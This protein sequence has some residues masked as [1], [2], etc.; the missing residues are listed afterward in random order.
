[1]INLK[2]LAIPVLILCFLF[3]YSESNAQIQDI[4]KKSRSNQSKKKSSK[5]SSSSRSSSSS[6]SSESDFDAADAMGCLFDAID[7]GGCLLSIFSNS[8]DDDDDYNY[9]SNSYYEE[10]YEYDYTPSENESTEEISVEY[11]ENLP[12]KPVE[13]KVVEEPPVDT[14]NTNPIVTKTEVVETE[15]IPEVYNHVPNSNL[16]TL[17]DE[18]IED[19]KPSLDINGNFA[20]AF[21]KGIDRN[22]TYVNF[23]PGLRANLGQVKFD[24]RFN[25]LTEFTDNTPDALKSWELL[26]MIDFAKKEELDIMVGTGLFREN[27]SESNFHEWYLGTKFQLANMKDYIEIDTRFSVDYETDVCPFFEIGGRYNIQF[28]NSNH[29][30]AYI[31]LGVMYQNY[32]QSHDIW[33]I[34]G[35]VVFNWH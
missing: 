4:K 15:T 7:L 17:K 2:R 19:F 24:F 12:L 31:N 27:F 16:S 9:S 13:K 18:G 6:S 3:N 22:Y 1:M 35:G 11:Y 14:T 33:G 28:I 32:Y 26:F 20:V 23:L 21:H 10:S 5:S 8:S 25:N 30:N 29:I 34:R